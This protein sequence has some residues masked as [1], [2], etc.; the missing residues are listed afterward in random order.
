MWKWINIYKTRNTIISSTWYETSNLHRRQKREVAWYNSRKRWY[1]LKSLVIMWNF[2][3]LNSKLPCSTN[4]PWEGKPGWAMAWCWPWPWCGERSTSPADWPICSAHAPPRPSKFDFATF[5][6]LHTH[7]SKYKYEN[8]WKYRN[9]T[10]NTP[11]QLTIPY[12]LIYTH[13]HWILLG[14]FPISWTATQAINP[15]WQT[16]IGEK[17]QTTQAQNTP[18]THYPPRW[19]SI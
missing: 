19:S 7:I 5:L 13:Q 15:H 3:L 10:V 6:G 18:P 2:N 12:T 4:W 16:Q 17:T 9:S 1:Q 11:G 8:E 14:F